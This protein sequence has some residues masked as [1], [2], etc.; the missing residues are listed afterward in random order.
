MCVR[1]TPSP[2]TPPPPRNSR[3]RGWLTRGNSPRLPS[4]RA[5][6]FQL[7]DADRKGRI[8]PM[9]LKVMLSAVLKE[10]GVSLTDGQVDQ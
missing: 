4:P 6:T 7:Y 9:D 3:A 5:V 8:S 10:N 1:E 2:R